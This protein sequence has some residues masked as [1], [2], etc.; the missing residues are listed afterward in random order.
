MKIQQISVASTCSGRSAIEQHVS[1][2]VSPPEF[3]QNYQRNI[4]CWFLDGCGSR[5]GEEL[6][7]EV[8]R[9]DIQQMLDK[10]DESWLEH[11]SLRRLRCC[12]ASL[13]I[14]IKAILK[15]HTNTSALR[16]CNCVGSEHVL[17]K[18]VIIVIFE[19]LRC[20]FLCFG[21]DCFQAEFPFQPRN[22]MRS[23]ESF[24]GT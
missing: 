24:C 1:A 18:N 23:P 15:S 7:D 9:E 17:P 6:P 3:C 19:Y 14:H 12:F 4:A 11:K 5:L 8:S 16:N 13:P 2:D 22:F 20:T 10:A 21:K